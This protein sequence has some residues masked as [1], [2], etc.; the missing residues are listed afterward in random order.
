LA[1][2]LAV[3]LAADAVGQPVLHFAHLVGQQGLAGEAA[4]PP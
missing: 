4:A 1:L 2:R 3:A